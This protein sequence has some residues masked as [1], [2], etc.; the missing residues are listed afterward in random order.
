[1][2]NVA[3]ERQKIML[4]GSVLKVVYWICFVS[5]EWILTEWAFKTGLQYLL[6]HLWIC[7]SNIYIIF[8]MIAGIIWNLKMWAEASCIYIHMRVKFQLVLILVMNK[9]HFIFRDVCWWWWALLVN[10]LKPQQRK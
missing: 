8:R 1:L 4:K 10:Y 6:I 9:N 2:T 5:F 3:P 7:I